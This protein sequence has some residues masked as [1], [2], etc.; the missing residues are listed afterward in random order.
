MTGSV[1]YQG[2]LKRKPVRKFWFPDKGKA[3]VIPLGKGKNKKS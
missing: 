1:W 2:Q 3:D